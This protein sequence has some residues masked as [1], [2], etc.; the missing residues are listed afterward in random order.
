MTTDK[1]LFA[2]RDS[3]LELM[4]FLFNLFLGV[5]VF[6][7]LELFVFNFAVFVLVLIFRSFF[8]ESA[9]NAG[10]KRI[11]K[12]AARWARYGFTREWVERIV[13]EFGAFPER[14]LFDLSFRN[15]TLD[16]A[17]L[18]ALLRD[19]VVFMEAHGTSSSSSSL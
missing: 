16:E 11:E 10:A 12:V 3:S 8:G 15:R 4:I 9:P 1:P 5:T 13:D 18:Q 19:Y 14:E 2:A 17:A 7:P 6:K